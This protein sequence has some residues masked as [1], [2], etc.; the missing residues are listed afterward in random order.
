MPHPT[1]TTVDPKLLALQLDIALCV[2]PLIHDMAEE[3]SE[4]ALVV[5][6]IADCWDRL[7]PAVREEYGSGPGPPG[8]ARFAGDY[9]E[10]VDRLWLEAPGLEPESVH[11]SEAER[12]CRIAWLQHLNRIRH[13]IRAAVPPPP[14]WLARFASPDAQTAR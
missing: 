1:T 2:V 13:R 11:D 9:A 8:E 5:A 4:R 3:S 14:E 12:L 7:P 6:D 10:A